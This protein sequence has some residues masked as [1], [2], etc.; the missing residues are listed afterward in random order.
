[1]PQSAV[2]S[3][4][5]VLIRSLFDRAIAAH[6]ENTEVGAMTAM[7]LADI[8]CE[9]L[10]KQALTHRGEMPQKEPAVHQLVEAIGRSIPTLANRPELQNASRL[11]AARNPVQ[12]AGQVPA[13]ASVKLH[14]TDALA[15]AR[16]LVR[17][18]FGEDFDAVS[19]ASLVATPDL[20]HGLV[21]AAGLLR[22][23]HLDDANAWASAVFEIIFARWQYWSVRAL[24]AVKPTLEPILPLSIKSIVART[25]GPQHPEVAPRIYPESLWREEWT[26]LSLG[27]SPSEL[28]RIQPL[29]ERADDFIEPPEPPRQVTT[30]T[31]ALAE[32]EFFVEA[33]ARQIWRI[34]STQ[35][36]MLIPTRARSQVAEGE[37][38]GS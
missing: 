3:L 27:F 15:F 8:A 33:L 5:L 21:Q 30:T 13:S 18:A 34:E 25:F 2:V 4:Q 26:L 12:H 36:E 16:V 17:E 9:S 6:R 22:E 28:L 35:P 24:R 31:P 7:L 38:Q 32:V 29:R 1:M 23:G 10:M 20:R 19:A 37:Q 14:L 11:R